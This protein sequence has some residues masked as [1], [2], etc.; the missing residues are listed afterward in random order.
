[1]FS[2]QESSFNEINSSKVWLPKDQQFEIEDEVIRSDEYDEDTNFLRE[3][4]KDE[5]DFNN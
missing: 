2:A 4:L 5:Y 1:M 3:E